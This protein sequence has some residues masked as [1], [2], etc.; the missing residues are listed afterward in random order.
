MHRVPQ[1]LSAMGGQSSL[2]RLPASRHTH[3]ALRLA[4][5][6]FLLFHKIWWGGVLQPEQNVGSVL[7]HLDRGSPSATRLGLHHRQKHTER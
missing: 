4:L 7:P 1:A 5:G 2:D 3:T 6:N